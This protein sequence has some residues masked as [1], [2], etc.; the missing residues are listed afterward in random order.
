MP[1]ARR[2]LLWRTK[3]DPRTFVE[4]VEFVT[5]V[6][7]V[8]RVVT[9]LGESLPG[10]APDEALVVAED[11]AAPVLER[12]AASLARHRNFD[13]ETDPPLV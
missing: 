10:G 12:F 4:R 6:G 1:T 13:R 11:G 3:H 7:N 8:D 9:P 5:A 2:T